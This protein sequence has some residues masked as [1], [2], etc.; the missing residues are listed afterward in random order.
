MNPY[1]NYSQM[2][3]PMMNS[4]NQFNNYVAGLQN[5]IG[6]LQHQMQGYQN[7]LANIQQTQNPMQNNGIVTQIVDSFEN[8]TANSV[9]MD[10]NGAIF[11]LRDGSEIQTRRWTP[12]GKI[13]TTSYKPIL[14]GFDS[15]ADNS[16][17]QTEKSKIG[18]S[19][20]VVEAIQEDISNIINKLD[21]IE[22][23]MTTKRTGSRSK[24]EVDADE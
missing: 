8:I 11:A 4:S 22:S 10:N 18:V 24:K 23:Y 1:Q 5:Q 20:E 13:T 2:N 12:D 17:N 21:M 3:T 6:V 14:G 16:A 7:A 19:D 15:K 9:P